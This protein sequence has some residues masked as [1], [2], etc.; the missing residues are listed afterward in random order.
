MGFLGKYPRYIN[1]IILWINLLIM[2]LRFDNF[3]AFRPVV[4]K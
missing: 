3:G 1:P 4:F 2:G